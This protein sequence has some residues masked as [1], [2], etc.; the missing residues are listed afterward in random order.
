MTAEKFGELVFIPD[1][2]L[3]GDRLQG[4]VAAE[5]QIAGFVKADLPQFPHRCAP[6]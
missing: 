6:A 1:A 4:Q 2:D 5:D 3:G